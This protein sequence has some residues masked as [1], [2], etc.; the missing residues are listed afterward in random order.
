MNEAYLVSGPLVDRL[1]ETLLHF[2]WQGALILAL[3]VAVRRLLFNGS[4]A[5]SRYALACLTMVLLS[6]PLGVY[7]SGPLSSVS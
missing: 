1:G 2:L 4:G 7:I 6:G 3:Y 5:Q